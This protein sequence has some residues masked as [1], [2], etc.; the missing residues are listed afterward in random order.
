MATPA[1]VNAGQPDHEG[2]RFAN[3]TDTVTIKVETTESFT[4]HTSLLLRESNFFKQ[5]EQL[6]L[7]NKSFDL[8]LPYKAITFEVFVKYLYSSR[9]PQTITCPIGDTLEAYKLGK[10]LE[11][12]N[13]A[14]LCDEHVRKQ[15]FFKS[16]HPR[17][18]DLS[19]LADLAD[20]PIKTLILE[21][22]AWL[23]V[24]GRHEASED[25]SATLNSL[26]AVTQPIWKELLASIIVQARKRSRDQATVYGHSNNGSG[27]F[28]I[29]NQTNPSGGLFGN[30]AN[31]NTG[32]GLFGNPNQINPPGGLFDQPLTSAGNNTCTLAGIGGGLFGSQQPKDTTGG[33]L[34]GDAETTNNIGGGLFGYNPRQASTGGSLF[35]QSNTNSATSTGGLFG[36]AHPSSGDAFGHAGGVGSASTTG[37]IVPFPRHKERELNGTTSV[38]QS[39]AAT[40]AYHHTSHEELRLHDYQG[41]RRS[42]EVEKPTN[43]P[44]AGV[45]PRQ[46]SVN[47][48]LAETRNTDASREAELAAKLVIENCVNPL[49]TTKAAGADALPAEAVATVN[50]TSAHISGMSTPEVIET[51]AS[52]SSLSKDAF[53]NKATAGGASVHD[54]D[55]TTKAVQNYDLLLARFSN[56]AKALHNFLRNA[57]ASDTGHHQHLIASSMN[58]EV[59][60]VHR[61]AQ[62]LL[63]AGY[64]YD[65]VDENTWAALDY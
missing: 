29:A 17:L 47:S 15:L 51:P 26:G 31:T 46:G 53:A 25:F 44:Q 55:A 59:A 41:G 49:S 61:A 42:G 60:K 6:L 27:L 18:S 38:Y 14:T 64:I 39:I 4:I 40:P 34:F 24:E 32:D 36:Q 21:R 1:A 5:Q 20:D 16:P 11:A 35:G 45:F 65:T 52:D 63:D 23:I 9:I 3:M 37:T 33:G 56:T 48:V 57:P 43:G 7:Q 30:S 50:T 8:P 54:R 13:F 2:P 62:E 28:G 10:F 22:I 19:M 58:L 12:E